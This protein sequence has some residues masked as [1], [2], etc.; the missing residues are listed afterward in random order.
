MK[1]QLFLSIVFALLGGVNSVLKAQQV[2]VKTNLVSDALLNVNL[3][4]EL[5]LE[6]KWTLDLTG[7]VNGW[8]L[9]HDR[10]WKHWLAQ[11]EV[12]YWFCDRFGGHF[13]GVHL[14]GGQYNI[15]GFNGR[16]NLLGT[17]ARKLSETRYQGWFAGAGVVYGYAWPVRKHFNIEAVIGLGWTYTR[18]EQFRCAGCGKKVDSSHPHNFVGPTKLAINLVYVF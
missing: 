1:R 14:L 8:T 13:I 15:G 10:R 18:Y 16:W 12:R 6:E 4:V 9:S 5:A 11:P 17:D 7:D 2:A 3:G